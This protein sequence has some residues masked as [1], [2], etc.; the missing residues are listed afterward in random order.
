MRQVLIQ[1]MDGHTHGR[2]IFAGSPISVAITGEINRRSVDFE[3]A[4]H[5]Q[6]G[7]VVLRYELGGPMTSF[8]PNRVTRS[9]TTY[10]VSKGVP[11][12]L[13]TTDGKAG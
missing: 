10:L 6:R 13:V 5:D 8:R 1:A 7:F 9:V 2:E 4:R 11:S 12:E 3:G